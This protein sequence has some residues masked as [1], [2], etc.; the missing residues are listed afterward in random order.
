MSLKVVA[1]SWK[2]ATLTKVFFVS[3]KTTRV[4]FLNECATLLVSFLTIF[5]RMLVDPTDRCRWVPF[6]CLF[7]LP[8]FEKYIQEKFPS[9]GQPASDAPTSLEITPAAATS[10]RTPGLVAAGAGTPAVVHPS[11]TPAVAPSPDSSTSS[12]LPSLSYVVSYLSQGYYLFVAPVN[13]KDFSGYSKI[14]KNPMSLQ[15]I[16][17]KSVSLIIPCMCHLCMFIRF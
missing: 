17:S 5:C 6:P 10:A 2:F 14:V 1:R 12:K 7:S 8:A 4:S 11:I 9:Q 15:I 16:T 13:P 3:S